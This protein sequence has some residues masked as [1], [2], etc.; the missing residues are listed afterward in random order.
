ITIDEIYFYGAGV[1]SKDSKKV[2]LKALKLF[3]DTKKIYTEGDLLAA[4]RATCKTEKGIACILGTG[5]NSCFYN[6][7]KI[8]NKLPSLGYVLGDDGS[9][10]HIGRKLLQY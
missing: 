8:A 10:N 3:F 1:N 6:G 4:A 2:I 9:G 5:S 7:K